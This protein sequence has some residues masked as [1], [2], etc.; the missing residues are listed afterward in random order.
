MRVKKGPENFRALLVTI[1]LKPDTPGK[2]VADYRDEG[3]AGA[4][5]TSMR[6][7]PSCRDV[8]SSSPSRV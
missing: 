1:R 2:R 3:G 6:I 4:S 8:S 7:M 5:G